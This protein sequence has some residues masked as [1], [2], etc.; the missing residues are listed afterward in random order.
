MS[1]FYAAYGRWA[2]QNGEWVMK[3]LALKKKL[4]EKGY[5]VPRYN[6]KVT[7]IGLTLL[8]SE[9]A[10]MSVTPSRE[11]QPEPGANYTV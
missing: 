9:M 4:M 6:S 1:E 7:V 11:Q 3:Q 8:D 5:A 2:Q 10:D